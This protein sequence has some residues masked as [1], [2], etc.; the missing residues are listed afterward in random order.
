M[1]KRPLPAGLCTLMLLALHAPALRADDAP[2][3]THRMTPIV[4]A[5]QHAKQSCVNIHSEKRAKSSEVLFSAGR[6]KKVNGM[7]TG[8]IVDERGYIVTNYHVVQ[9]VEALRVTLCD[10]GAFDARV[11]SYDSR[12]DLA[13]IKIDSPRPLSV[14][15][16]GTS[17][18]LMLGEDVLAIGN[19]FGYEHTVTRGI[20]S[21]LSRDVEVNEDVAYKNLIQI[22]A[23]INPGN[24]GGPLLNQDGEVIGINVAIRAGAQKIG[25]AIPIDDARVIIARLLNIERLNSHYHGLEVADRK[26]GAERKLVVRSAQAGSP[27]AQAGLQP[28]DV[29]VKAGPVNVIDGA[30][31]ER[32]LLGRNVGEKVEIIVDRSGSGR[33]TVMLEVATLS[34]ERSTPAKRS[35]PDAV[36]AAPNPTADNAEKTWSLLGLRLNKLATADQKLTGQPYRGG[37]LVTE[38]RPQSP[39]ELNGLRKGDVLVGLHVWETISP[40]NVN[41][42]LSHPQ[43]TTFN[44]IKFYILRERETLYGHFQVASQASHSN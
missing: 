5:V 31:F 1:T 20:I 36:A 7:G 15:P 3:A 34:P 12:E 25:F 8:I 26:Q 28:G 2:S 42:V 22:D 38:V 24:S 19:A 37:M 4:R 18:D 29:V 27:A 21:A 32:A 17:S 33:E 43:I 40:E 16:F 11:V 41:Y 6:D 35:L 30:D 13:I 44:P 39:A 10:G 9:D 14:M 23:A